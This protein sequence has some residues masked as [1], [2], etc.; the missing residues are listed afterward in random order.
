MN[1]FISPFMCVGGGVFPSIDFILLVK[2]E[3]KKAKENKGKIYL[4]FCLLIFRSV[5]FLSNFCYCSV[6]IITILVIKAIIIIII[7]R[8]CMSII[9]TLSLH[10][11]YSIFFFF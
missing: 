3:T 8:S 4:K 10:N 5:F 9:T 7:I 11:V 2:N 1:V 6:N